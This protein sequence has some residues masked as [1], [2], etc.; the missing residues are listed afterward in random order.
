M[1]LF[2]RP[3]ERV[4]L[5]TLF[6]LLVVLAGTLGLPAAH[7]LAT[8]ISTISQVKDINSPYRRW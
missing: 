5:S 3:S 6:A 2:H 7:P 8:V 1:I 4:P